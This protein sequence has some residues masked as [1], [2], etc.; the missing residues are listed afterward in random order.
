MF[1]VR[2]DRKYYTYEYIFDVLISMLINI[3]ERWIIL[4]V[5]ILVILVQAFVAFPSFVLLLKGEKVQIAICCIDERANELKG[6]LQ[7]I[8]ASGGVDILGV[9]RKKDLKCK[10][11]IKQELYCK[12]IEVEDYDTHRYVRHNMKGI[13]SQRN[14]ALDYAKHHNYD[15]LI[16]IDSDIRISRYT[17]M[18]LQVGIM[19]ADI[20]CVPYGIRWS[21]MEP[22]LGYENPARIE[23]A[24]SGV[25]PF[26]RC[27]VAGM[28]CTCISIRSDKIPKTFEYGKILDIEGEDIGFFLQARRMNALVVSTSWHVVHHIA[29]ADVN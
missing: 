17:L 12:Y 2:Y 7:A 6:C 10:H 22:V 19:F 1:A 28:G 16:F 8:R 23:R 18:Y 4:C 21:N 9:F 15:N 29:D 26:Y 13:A 24:K 3:R 5:L 11:I 25:W 14:A 27:T 20:S